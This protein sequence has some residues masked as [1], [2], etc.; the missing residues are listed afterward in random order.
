MVSRTLVEV[1][2]PLCLLYIYKHKLTFF[3]SLKKKKLFIFLF[4]F[5]QCAL[6]VPKVWSPKRSCVFLRSM[7]SEF[8]LNAYVGQLIRT[9]CLVLFEYTHWQSIYVSTNTEL[10]VIF[11][12]CSRNPSQHYSR[13]CIPNRWS[14]NHQPRMPNHCT[15]WLASLLYIY[16][17]STF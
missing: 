14:F 7:C 2:W 17:Y 16:I 8:Q 9:L 3:F 13:H 11:S 10:E 6:S 5:R 15:H 12:S 4:I 1:C